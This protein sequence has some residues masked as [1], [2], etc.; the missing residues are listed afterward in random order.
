M[1]TQIFPTEIIENTTEAY[2]PQVTVRSQII[3]ISVLAIL[4]AALISLPYIKI[5]VSTNSSGI[6]RTVAEKSDFKA[7][8]SGR[9]SS[10]L[11]KEN[12]KVETGQNLVVLASEMLDSKISLVKFQQIEKQQFIHDLS[13][14]T[15]L[16]SVNLLSVR[17]LRSSLFAQQYNQLTYQLQESLQQ[18]RKIKKE[19]DTDRMLYK[20]KVISMREFDE[21]E[22]TYKRLLAEYRSTIER[23]LSQWQS[24]LTTHQIAIAEIQA[25]ESQLLKEKELYTI[26]APVSG[27]I[28]QLVGKY[29]GSYVQAGEGLGLI[30]PDSSLLV[31][32]YISPKDM[33][34][35]KKGMKVT[36]Q[37]DALNYNDWGFAYGEINEIANDFEV[38]EK[39]PVFRVKCRLDTRSLKLKN[40]YATTLKK[41]MTLRARFIVTERSLYQLL[42]DKVD[43]WL[44]P[45]QKS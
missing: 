29:P 28:Q 14:L 8:T 25:Q 36:Y 27:T 16:D 2:L 33:G 19:L 10:W 20:E 7:I 42:Y 21:K 31:E 41:G 45:L 44:N 35:L 40:G 13:I 17:G 12:Q 4:I 26:K 23:Q 37:I 22:Y 24:D 43:D 11:V 39:Q 30:S 34:L 6:V 9:V 32:C 15:R 3:Y 1:A 18:Q 5:S 38:I